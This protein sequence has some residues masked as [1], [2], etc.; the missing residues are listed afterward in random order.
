MSPQ[1]ADAIAA[2]EKIN[3]QVGL[4]RDL[5]SV[6]ARRVVLKMRRMTN[7]ALADFEAGARA[8][9][10]AR[11]EDQAAFRS[12]MAAVRNVVALHQASW[13]AVSLDERT[14][15]YLASSENVR[16]KIDELMLWLRRLP[17]K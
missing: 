3:S 14:E 13:P 6:D 11:P 15:D 2:L 9:L 1:L 5:S 16:V 7:A 8:Y 10:A 17:E 4:R 12:R